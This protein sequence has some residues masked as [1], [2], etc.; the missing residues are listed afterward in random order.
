MKS[1]M[2]LAIFCF[3][4][5]NA[6]QAD[7]VLFSTYKSENIKETLQ[8]SYNGLSDEEKLDTLLQ[9]QNYIEVLKHLWSEPDVCK[10]LTWLEKKIN[11]NHPILIF[12]LAEDYYLKDPTLECF[13]TKT[14]P[15]I[16]AGATRTLLDTRCTK[17]NSV[18]SC[19]DQLLATYHQRIVEKCLE[20]YTLEQMEE[21][22]IANA[23]LFKSENLIVQERV[24][25]S[26]VDKTDIP[27]PKWVFTHG[28]SAFMDEENLVPESEFNLI[29][30]KGALEI[31]G[32]IN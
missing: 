19:V 1:I 4:L 6:A 18:S 31:L 13:L 24:F 27:S 23:D 32:M 10:R 28:A 17:D 16:I 30:K 29:R 5:G 22:I 25:K 11:E 7:V 9:E 15:W 21:Y 8:K 3:C 12:E 26:L 14:M 2:F 20:T